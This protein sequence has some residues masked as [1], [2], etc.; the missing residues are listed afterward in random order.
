VMELYQLIAQALGYRLHTV[1]RLIRDGSVSAEHYSNEVIHVNGVSTY[2]KYKAAGPG[3]S[4]I[5]NQEY[6]LLL[7]ADYAILAAMGEDVPERYRS[8]RSELASELATIG[9][10]GEQTKQNL[11]GFLLSR[12][13]SQESCARILG[14]A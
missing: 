8:L 14:A 2:R 1:R 4:Y 12:G 11:T 10:S 5:D 7:Q 6:Y 3:K 9:V 13:V